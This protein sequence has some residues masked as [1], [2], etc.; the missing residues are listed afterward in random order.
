MDE[1]TRKL[2]KGEG[3]G[4]D[5]VQDIQ[6]RTE[7]KVDELCDDNGDEEKERR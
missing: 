7:E 4:T 3:V 2:D 6:K 1:L 5:V